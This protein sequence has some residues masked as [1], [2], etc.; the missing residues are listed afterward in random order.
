MDE[1]ID[2]AVALAAAAHGIAVHLEGDV[3]DH[4]SLHRG[5]VERELE[6]VHGRLEVHE[7]A[8]K[9]IADLVGGKLA[10]EGV[11]VVVDVFAHLR[12]HRLGQVKAVFLVEHIGDAA[13]ARLR[14]DAD[15]GLVAAPDILRIDREV[16]H[17]PRQ[18]G[19]FLQFALA[20]VEAFLDRI[21]VRPGEG[22]EDEFADVGMPLAHG[23]ARD[24]LVDVAQAGQVG[25]VESCRD[26]VAVHVQGHVD[27]VEIAGAFSVT[28][29]SAL[30]TVGPGHQAQLGRGGAGAAVIVSVQGDEHGIAT[31]QMTAHPLDHVGVDVRRGPLHRVGQ[32]DNHLFLRRRLPDIDDGIAALQREIEFGV[33]EGFGRILQHDLGL[34]NGRDELLHQLRALDRD[35]A[36]LFAGRVA[37]GDAAL[38]GRGGVVDMDDGALRSGDGLEGAADEVLARLHQHLHGDVGGDAVLVDEAAQEIEFRVRGRGKADLDLLEADLAEQVEELELF[39]HRHGLRER[40]ISVAKVDAAP[41][42]GMRDR[43]VRPLPVRQGDRGEGPVLADGF[44]FHGV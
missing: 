13:L 23:H 1:G 25:K 3:A 6:E 26:A 43:P 36:D 34:R 31:V 20:A 37:E 7:F 10:T 5:V 16:R 22:G 2:G 44:R 19:A 29:E 12:V 8:E 33:G 27:D 35:V 32:V 18:I 15:D 30:D 14:V 9:Q 42:R 28:E 4:F 17:A 11:G 40:L 24:P 21:L 41:D 39:L 38:Q